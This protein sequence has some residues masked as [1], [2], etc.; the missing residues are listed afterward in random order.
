LQVFQFRRM[1]KK[2]VWN[3]TG[4][5]DGRVRPEGGVGS[6]VHQSGCYVTGLL[7]S[8]HRLQSG[9]DSPGLTQSRGA[10]DQMHPHSRIVVFT[11]IFG[12][13]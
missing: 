11:W 12:H 10:N 13:F 5:I 9:I 2:V 6:T 8:G 4:G 1:H 7:Q 3:K